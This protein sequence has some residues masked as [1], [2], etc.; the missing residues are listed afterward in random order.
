MH[1]GGTEVTE[2]VAMRRKSLAWFWL[3]LGF[4]C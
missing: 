4:Y 1:H 2:K 3:V